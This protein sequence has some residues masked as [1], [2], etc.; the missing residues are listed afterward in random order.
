MAVDVPTVFV[1]WEAFTGWLLD[2]TGRCPRNV[3]QTLAR[4]VEDCALDIFD[5][6]IAARWRPDVRA[7]ALRG[8]NADLE[9]L[10][11]L[12][13]LAHAQ[14]CL[15]PGAYEHACREIDAAGR[16]V[17]GWLRAGGAP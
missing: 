6:L 11:L 10:R 9:R 7:N 13:R 14:R 17:G 3:R 5:A 8:A 16:Q 15:D 1:Q 4:R 12:L 2:R